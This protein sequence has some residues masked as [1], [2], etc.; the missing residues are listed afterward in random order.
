[1]NGQ[2]LNVGVDI[3]GTN[4]KFGITDENGKILLQEK[5]RTESDRGSDL[6]ILSIIQGIDTIL[7]KAHLRH[8]DIKS[9]GL[10]VP[11]TADSSN[12]VVVYA[13][14]LSWKKV[15]ISKPIQQACNIP[16]YIVQDTR[17]AAWAEYLVGAGKGLR[18]VASVT[19][20]TGIGC[21]MVFDGRIFHG[22]LNTAGEFGHQI[23][24]I[25]GNLCNCGR[26]GCLEA[27]AGGL[28][29]LRDAKQ[30]IPDIHDLLHKNPS[31]IGV[32]DV[33]QLAL[34]GNIGARQLTNSV[35]KI[36]GMG[37]VNLIN[38]SSVELICLSGGISNAPAELLLDP[39]REFIRERA[40]V[41]VA[42]KV[43]V[44]SSALGEDAPLIGAA[45]LHREGANQVS[46]RQ[47]V[48]IR[49]G[50]RSFSSP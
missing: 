37:L 48:P 8:V 23:V 32:N 26:R 38:I 30:R 14:N 43:R 7:E 47:T 20:G 50:L 25:D 19:L 27:Y 24:E 10:G 2:M 39:L 28:A 33:F 34:E 35:V 41:A 40:Y 17:A 46:A 16:V 6:V 31:E 3:G 9:I 45:L 18:S 15:E 42:D 44:C 12:G 5:V 21:G 22:T 4:I 1:M 11:G 29:I 13:P 49:D 36:I